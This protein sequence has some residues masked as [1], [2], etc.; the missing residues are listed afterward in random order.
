MQLYCIILF[1]KLQYINHN[2]LWNIFKNNLTNSYKCDIIH[3]ALMCANAF[4]IAAAPLGIGGGSLFC[5]RSGCSGRLSA[6]HCRL[7]MILYYPIPL[8][9]SGAFWCALVIAYLKFRFYYCQKRKAALYTLP[10]SL[11][12][13]Y[14]SPLSLILWYSFFS[15]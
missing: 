7:L 8:S 11:V 3:L 13:S 5:V 4:Y 10:L 14:C 2:I 12:F 15:L 6:A 1:Q 9:L